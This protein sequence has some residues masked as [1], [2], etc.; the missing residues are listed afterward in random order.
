[1]LTV[2]GAPLVAASSC[3]TLL[4]EVSRPKVTVPV[5]AIVA[6]AIELAINVAGVAVFHPV[7]EWVA[8]AVLPLSAVSA[9][10][11][12][13]PLYKTSVTGVAIA[14]ASASRRALRKAAFALLDII[15]PS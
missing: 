5:L 12:G 14:A 11:G 8:S 3:C 6:S 15:E 7:I 10:T 13:V 9:V 1:V 4:P 2:I